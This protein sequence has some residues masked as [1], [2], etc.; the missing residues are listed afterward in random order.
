MRFTFLSPEFFYKFKSFRDFVLPLSNDFPPPVFYFCFAEFF[1]IASLM[2][3]KNL[4]MLVAHN[5]YGAFNS[6][7]GGGNDTARVAR[8]LSAGIYAAYIALAKF[9]A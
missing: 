1:T 6:V 3:R 7:H 8:S 4:S 2:G 5:G 9:I